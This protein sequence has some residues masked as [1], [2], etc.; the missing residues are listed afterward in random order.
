[1]RFA[2]H[3]LAGLIAI[4]NKDDAFRAFIFCV[5]TRNN[6]FANVVPHA[7]FVALRNSDALHVVW[8]HSQRA[9][10]V[11]I[12]VGVLAFVQRDALAA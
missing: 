12:P 7:N 10:L 2:G 5:D 6:H 9:G 8:V 1:M 11:E 3:Q 4:A